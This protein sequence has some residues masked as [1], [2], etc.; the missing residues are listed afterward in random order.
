M[1]SA[2]NPGPLSA[3][4][5][6]PGAGGGGCTEL[7]DVD[8]GDCFYAPVQWAVKEKVTTGTSATE[9]APDPPC[10]RVQIITFPWRVADSRLVCNFYGQPLDVTVRP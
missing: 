10:T 7:T 6:S 1:Y 3:G 9:F 2:S 5:G 4:P 8:S